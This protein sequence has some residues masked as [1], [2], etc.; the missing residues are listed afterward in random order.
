MSFK[1]APDFGGGATA[2][3]CC[4][5]Q[6]YIWPIAA[7]GLSRRAVCGRVLYMRRYL[8]DLIN[9]LADQRSKEN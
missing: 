3:L 1:S 5:I 9:D 7:G 8:K 6:H 2:F 4:V